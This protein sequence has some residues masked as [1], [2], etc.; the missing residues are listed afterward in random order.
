MKVLITGGTGFLGKHLIGHQSIGK[1]S[2]LSLVRKESLGCSQVEYRELIG[3][4][5]DLSYQNMLLKPSTRK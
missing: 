2:V 3:D 1:H 4:L 5:N